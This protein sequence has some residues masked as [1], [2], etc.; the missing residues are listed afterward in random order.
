M[1]EFTEELMVHHAPIALAEHVEALQA[2]GRYTFTKEAAFKAVG[3]TE[4]AFRFAAIRLAAKGRVVSPRRGFFVVV[5]IEYRDAGAPP[6]AWYIH[7]LMAFQGLPYYVALLSAAALHGAGHQQPQEFQ[8][9]TSQPLRIVQAGRARIR[10]FKKS[11]VEQTRVVEMKTETGSM[12][13]STPEATAFDL[14]A[15]YRSVGHLNNV[16]TVLADL[17]EKID[18]KELARAAKSGVEPPHV[19]RLGYLL[20]QVGGRSA[21]GPLF[22][23]FSRQ[24]ARSV[25]LQAGKAATGAQENRRWKVLVNMHVEVDR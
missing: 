21:T 19:Q 8:V 17:I 1:L 12:R 9:I 18:P 4:T 20:E 23:W 7:D 25:P 11:G 2:S 14:V 6:P 15:F 10:F 16:A 5:P 22:D 3:A 24:S 13:V